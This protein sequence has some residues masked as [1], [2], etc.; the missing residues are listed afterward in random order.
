MRYNR[1]QLNG[2]KD[3]EMLHYQKMI[4]MRQE[5][6]KRALYQH[7]YHHNMTT[8]SV[9]EVSVHG[10]YCACVCVCD[11][12]HLISLL[13]IITMTGHDYHNVSLLYRA[14]LLYKNQLYQHIQRKDHFSLQ[15][16]KR[17]FNNMWVIYFSM[18]NYE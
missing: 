6:R 9:I 10:H 15:D 12:F 18:Y 7:Y 13:M 3:W 2:I 17:W 4:I 14:F 5:E 1:R 8:L 11:S 16:Y